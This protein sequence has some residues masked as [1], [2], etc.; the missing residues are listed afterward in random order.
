MKVALVFDGLGFG[1]IERV[2]VNYAKL[3]L[4]LGYQVD[5]YNMKPELNDM[6]KEFDSRCNFFD[7]KMPDLIVSDRYMLMVKRWRWENTFIQLYIQ[8]QSY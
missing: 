8:L 2:G 3:F 4:D 1:G 7:K 6:V 5:I